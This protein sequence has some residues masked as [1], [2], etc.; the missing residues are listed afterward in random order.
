[1]ATMNELS[2]P[3]R[4]IRE[5]IFGVETQGEFAGLLGYSQST[6]S[7]VETGRV[8]LDR[9]FMDRVRELAKLRGI[10]WNDS[11]FFEVPERRRRRA[12]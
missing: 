3:A 4:F 1:M 8:R 6:I 12:A 11:W 2:T 9:E 7:R 10:K 5:R